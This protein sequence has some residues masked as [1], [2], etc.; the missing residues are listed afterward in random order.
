M[1][2]ASTVPLSNYPKWLL[3]EPL[4]FLLHIDTANISSSAIYHPFFFL[5]V[6]RVDFTPVFR[7]CM[8]LFPKCSFTRRRGCRGDLRWIPPMWC[9]KGF[10]GAIPKAQMQ[11]GFFYVEWSI[12]KYVRYV[13]ISS[14]WDDIDSGF[15]IRGN[16]GKAASLIFQSK[17][18]VTIIE[19]HGNRS[20]YYNLRRVKEGSD[21]VVYVQPVDSSKRPVKHFITKLE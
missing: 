4:E 21:N 6:K 16:K 14:D 17:P 7:N 5:L 13:G 11:T 19:I 10:S 1:L 15:C 3:T 18:T 12:Q 9:T 8:I 2:I 20:R